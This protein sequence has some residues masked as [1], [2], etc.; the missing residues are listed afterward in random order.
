MLVELFNIFL[1]LQK[2]KNMLEFFF[3]PFL[4]VITRS[5]HKLALQL[6]LQKHFILDYT[7]LKKIPFSETFKWNRLHAEWNRFDAD[8]IWQLLRTP[9]NYMQT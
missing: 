9:T 1:N 8:N 4:L 6:Q 2:N 7:S 3:L 5:Y